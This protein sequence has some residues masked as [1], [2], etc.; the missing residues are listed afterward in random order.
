M[1]GFFRPKAVA[2]NAPS[3]GIRLSSIPDVIYAIGDIHGCLDKLQRLQSTII[4]D[5]ADI[6]G[7]KIIV[8]LGDYIDRGPASARTLDWLMQEAPPGFRRICLRGNHEA[9]LLEALDKPGSCRDWLKWG[10]Q[11]TLRSYGIDPEYFERLSGRARGQVLN[12]FVPPDQV[13]FLRSCPYYLWTPGFLFVHAGI[14]PG[15]ALEHRL[16]GT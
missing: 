8:T 14:R 7:D 16:P 9:L 4:A 5:A 15:I 11:E 1:F 12:S 6:D 3:L 2:S 13:A 10:G